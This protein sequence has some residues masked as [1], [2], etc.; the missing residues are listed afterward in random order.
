MNKIEKLD[1][2]YF[3]IEDDTQNTDC[4]N[5]SKMKECLK[6]CLKEVLNEDKKIFPVCLK[7][8]TEK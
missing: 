5:C 2:I 6:E 7:I 4:F 3:G 8:E 1:R